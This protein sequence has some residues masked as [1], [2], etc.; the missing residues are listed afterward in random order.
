MLFLCI[1][2]IP[3]YSQRNLADSMHRLL[4]NEK[5]DSNRVKHLW[6]MADYAGIYNPD[7]AI[8]LAQEAVELA[9]TIQYKEGESRSLGIL[10]NSYM[11]IGNYPRA[12]EFNFAKLIIEE[13][14]SQPRNLASVMMNIG[15]VYMYQEEYR[16]A[17][18]YYSKSDSIIEAANLSKIRYNIYQNIGDTYD[19]LNILDSA[20][21]FYNR[22]LAESRL[23]NNIN[24][25]GAAETGLGHIYRKQSNYLLSLDH[26]KAALINLAQSGDDDLLTE[27]HLG[28][29][30]LYSLFKNFDSSISHARKSF[31]LAYTG[32]FISRQLDAATFLTNIYKHNKNLDSAFAYL[33]IEKALGD[34]VYSKYR[35]RQSQILSSDEQLRQRALAEAKKKE[36]K[37]RSKRLQLLFIGIFIPGLFLITLL[38]S[39]IRLHL[40]AIKLLG[41]LSLLIFFEYLTLLLHPTV[42]RLT[43]YTPVLEIFIFVVIAAVLIPLHHRAEHWLIHK[44][45][46]RHLKH[47]EESKKEKSR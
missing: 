22:A 46:H 4:N 24:Y 37:E 40:K 9:R 10:A 11:R 32:G 15:I 20:F 43:N 25:T 8:L 28:L 34:S 29:A 38:L 42:A 6:R 27:A 21:Y 33:S 45:L 7:T 44:L 23:L 41:I 26:Y 35:V 17:L 47:Q 16:K 2:I 13:K 5:T 18:E 14:G 19:R 1:Q 12:L 39:R 30:Q 3:C 36:E 31:D